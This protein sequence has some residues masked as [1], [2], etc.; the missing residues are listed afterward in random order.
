[1]DCQHNTALPV[2]EASSRMLL[3]T[4]LDKHPKHRF[5]TVHNPRDFVKIDFRIGQNTPQGIEVRGTPNK[6]LQQKGK[7]YTIVG[8]LLPHEEAKND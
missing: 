7:G 8:F 2:K 6:N 4:I 1:M 3:Q 5:R